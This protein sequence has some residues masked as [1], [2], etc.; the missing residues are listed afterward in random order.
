[1][2]CI[3]SLYVILGALFWLVPMNGVEAPA[4]IAYLSWGSLAAN[5][6]SLP[7]VEPNGFKSNPR[8]GPTLPVEY[9]RQNSDGRLSL[10]I[11]SG[12]G[13]LGTE[14]LIKEVETFYATYR[15]DNVSQARSAL[16]A[17]E[18]VSAENIGYV[19][20]QDSTYRRKDYNVRTGKTTLQK[21]TI[22]DDYYTDHTL[23]QRIVSWARENGYTAVIW[24][25]LQ[26]TF[27][28]N[29]L[30]LNNLKAHLD[31]LEKDD[32]KRAYC[33]LQITPEIQQQTRFGTALK[34]YASDRLLSFFQEN[35]QEMTFPQCIDIIY[36]NR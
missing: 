32:L 8:T 28:K 36:L 34:N 5:P 25:D 10:V 18:G 27:T 9:A 31:S 1:M 15:G 19:N 14:P 3:R 21:G 24:T 35:P 23:L 29:T 11:A 26:P 2:Y 13:K 16:Q 4:K 17:R 6:G 12:F 7:L 33:Y 22:G 20:L 30:T